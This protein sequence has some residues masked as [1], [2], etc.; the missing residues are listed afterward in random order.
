MQNMVAS[1]RQRSKRHTLVV[2]HGT[3]IIFAVK[4]QHFGYYLLLWNGSTIHWVWKATIK[5]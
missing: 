5:N 3:E 2:E 1:L 4:P